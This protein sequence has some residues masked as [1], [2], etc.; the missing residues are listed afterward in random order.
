MK[1]CFI[2]FL[3]A[4]TAFLFSGCVLESGSA[5]GPIHPLGVWWWNTHLI[6]DS[7]YLN[8]AVRNHV[9]EIYLARPEQDIRDFGPEIEEFIEKASTRGIKVYLL[10][11]FGYIPYEYPRL[12]DALRLYKD[13]QARVPEI[14]RF[15]GIHLDIEFHADYPD[16]KDKDKQPEV[17]AEYLAL[18]VRLRSE[19]PGIPMDIDIPAW[20]D[21]IVSYRGAERPLYRIL[22]DLVDRV[23]VMSYRDTAE[24]MYEIAR[25][26]VSY[27]ISV[28]KPIILGAELESK[29]GDH[30]SYMEEGRL[31]LY[32][33]LELLKDIV[34][35]PKAGASIHHMATWFKLHD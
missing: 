6:Q 30:V 14:R 18:I 4:I 32:K 27:A 28:N 10:L 12:Q 21:H 3:F 8:F 25:E 2:F 22:I 26:E 24:A 13:Y 17:L 9:D 1:R 20:Y 11:G 33:Q 19:M 15:D 31:Y 16:W 5:D 34:N 29:E 7:R 35:Y 23:F